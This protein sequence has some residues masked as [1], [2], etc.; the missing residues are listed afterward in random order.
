MAVFENLDLEFKE[1]YVPELKKDIVAFANTEGGSLYIGIRKD[2]VVVGVDDPDDVMLRVASGLKDGIRP[3]IMPFVKIQNIERDGKS[4]VE[5]A[6]EIGT[7]RPYYLQDKGLKPSGVYVRKGSASQPL[8]DEGIREMILE[9]SGKSYEKCRSMNQELTFTV[10]QKEM[11]ARN[12]ESGITQMRTLRMIDENGL[13]TNLALL[14][15]D[16]CEHTIKVAIFQGIEKTVFRDRKEF[17]G[18]LLHQ[19]NEIYHMIDMFNKTMATFSGLNRTDKRDYPEDAVRESLLNCIVHRDYSFSGSTL[20]NLYDDRIEFVSLGGLVSGLSMEAVLMGVS[21]SRN[22]N[23]AAVFYR[24]RLIE[25]YGTGIGKIQRLY[26]NESTPIFETAKGVFRVVLPNCN[27]NTVSDNV[28]HH[29]TIKIEE[30]MKTETEVISGTKATVV[31]SSDS[32]ELVYRL[33]KEKGQIKRKDVENLLDVKSTR[34][35]VILNTMVEEG[36]LRINGTG[37][38]T[39]YEI[40]Q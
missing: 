24:M 26:K 5:V 27:D 18:S 8:S 2:G 31:H 23:L 30:V 29:T 32:M 9:S 39:F 1:I 17:S 21:Q 33:A 16:Q 34:A 22:P 38:G 19:L 37:R 3:D 40:N 7:G 10:F 12:M 11:A 28:S 4:V 20:I 13:F 25:S 15:S 14:L 35:Y 36:R 6:V